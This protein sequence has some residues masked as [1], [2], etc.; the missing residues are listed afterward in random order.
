MCAAMGA[1]G[2]VGA[3]GMKSVHAMCVRCVCV[4]AVCTLC[5]AAVC[6]LRVFA[7]VWGLGRGPTLQEGTLVWC[8]L[9]CPPTLLHSPGLTMPVAADA[10]VDSLRE[11]QV[12]VWGGLRHS[13]LHR[14]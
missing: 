2:A 9:L 10:S 11:S 14:R 6:A 5:V 4:L 3:V 12:R 8:C 13:R 7:W 1:V